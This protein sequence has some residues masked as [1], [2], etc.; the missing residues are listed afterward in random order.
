MSIGQFMTTAGRV[1]NNLLG[2]FL[3]WA[4][5]GLL[6][7][8]FAV[9]VCFLAALRF[10]KPEDDDAL[11]VFA[12][13]A[14]FII[15]RVFGGTWIRAFKRGKRSGA[16]L[17]SSDHVFSI[18]ERTKAPA[19]LL[20]PEEAFRLAPEA[21]IV[22]A[23]AG[24][25]IQSAAWTSRVLC[26]LRAEIPGGAFQKSV[27]AISGVSGGSV[28]TL[29]Y[30]RCLE[31]P[32][33]DVRPAKWSQDSSLEAVAWGLTHPDL[34]RVFFP[35]PATRWSLADRGWALERSL[36]KIAHFERTERRFSEA[37]SDC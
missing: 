26:G 5:V 34:R 29:V 36:L 3:I 2:G 27:L 25:G 8:I 9:M 30:L 37:H 18:V 32:E 24:G 21:V 1:E 19:K 11:E 20:R 16:A 7:G 28:G 13:P 22:V 12:F 4:A 10:A 17:G 35:G 33:K 15:R 6:A 14:F 31:R 23:A